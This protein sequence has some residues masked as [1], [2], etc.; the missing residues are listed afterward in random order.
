MKSTTFT[1]EISGKKFPIAQKSTGLGLSSELL[2][3]IQLTH[4]QFKESS[5][6][7]FEEINDLRKLFIQ[8]QLQQAKIELE[9]SQNTEN[10]SIPQNT[11]DTIATDDEQEPLS[12]GQR[13][14]DKVAEFGGSWTFIISFG[15]FI[16]IWICLNVFLLGKHSYD[17]YP[18]ILLNLILSCVAAIQAPIIMMSQNRQEQKD[19]SRAKKD[20][21][22]NLKSELEIRN[23]HEKLDHLMIQQHERLLEIQESQLELL[24]DYFN[25]QKTD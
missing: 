19:R 13:I 12:Q 4:S 17:P 22:V 3:F 23:L 8:F 24:T 7:S 20:Y 6:L 1:S 2:K 15:V 21:M 11:E 25:R 18:F 5:A 9:Q 14:A 10:V 16:T